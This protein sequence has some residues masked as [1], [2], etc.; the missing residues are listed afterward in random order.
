MT[1]EFFVKQKPLEGVD[2]YLIEVHGAIDMSRAME[3]E[4]I[5]RGVIHTGKERLVFD[6]SNL[7]Y[8]NTKGL[9]VLLTIQKYW[10]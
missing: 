4:E 7:V 1:V 6:L 2:A 10:Q 3:L 8:I 9:G 5:A